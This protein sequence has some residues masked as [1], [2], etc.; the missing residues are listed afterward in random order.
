MK[1]VNFTYVVE[2]KEKSLKAKKKTTKV[3]VFDMKRLLIRISQARDISLDE[4]LRV[5]DSA[6]PS[7][8]EEENYV[9]MTKC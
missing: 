2:L 5:F 9:G 8:H 3:I 6:V 1:R 7:H 4:L